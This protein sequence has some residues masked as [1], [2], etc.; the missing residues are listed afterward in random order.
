MHWSLNWKEE[1][2]LFEKRP[3]LLYYYVFG[4]HHQA[5]QMKEESLVEC[6]EGWRRR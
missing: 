2:F 5:E 3:P 1:K 6:I 4:M